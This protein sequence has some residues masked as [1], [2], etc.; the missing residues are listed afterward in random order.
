MKKFI[1]AIIIIHVIVVVVFV[2]RFNIKK[3]TVPKPSPVI[4]V[5]IGNAEEKK[6]LIRVALPKPNDVIKSPLV[7]KGEARGNWFF[8]ASFPIKLINS[9]GKEVPLSQGY[10]MTAENWMTTDFV[11]FE[12]AITFPLQKAGKGKLI[13]MKD[14]PSGLPQFEDELVIPISFGQ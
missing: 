7:I 8:E 4:I 5:D 3:E 1:P 13:L 2:W 11:P 9:E 10:I 6:D 14:N 12:Q